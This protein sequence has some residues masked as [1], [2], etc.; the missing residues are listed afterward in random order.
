MVHTPSAS[1]MQAGS[2]PS[3]VGAYSLPASRPI[4][5]SSCRPSIEATTNDDSVREV[6][7]IR[8]V[9]FILSKNTQ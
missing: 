4:T 2:D 8:F 7:V 1:L 3:N 6:I 5:N 9:R